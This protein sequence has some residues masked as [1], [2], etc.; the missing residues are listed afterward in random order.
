MGEPTW[1]VA[2]ASSDRQHVNQHFGM[3]TGFAVYEIAPEAVR[4]REVLQSVACNTHN[5]RVGERVQLLDGC[6]L[7]F[8]VAIGEAAKRQLADAGITAL[9]VQQGAAISSLL[10]KLQAQSVAQV[11]TLAPFKPPVPSKQAEEKFLAMLANGWD[12]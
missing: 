7:L 1:K 9:V 2:F 11:G 5:G 10:E 3:A 8:C 4:L 6:R 12:E